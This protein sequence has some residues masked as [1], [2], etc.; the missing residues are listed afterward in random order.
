[1]NFLFAVF[2]L[3]FAPLLQAPN[4][5]AE[6]SVLS[7]SEIQ[8]LAKLVSKYFAA[9]AQESKES[10]ALEKVYSKIQ[11]FEK[12]KKV[13]N[14]LKHCKPWETV[15]DIA[16]DYSKSLSAGSESVQEFQLSEGVK[17][18]YAV[19]M[20]KKYNSKTAWPVLLIIPERGG[21][22]PKDSLSPWKH[23]AIQ[24][25]FILCAPQLP[26]S[27]KSWLEPEGY[28]IVLSCFGRLL[29]Q[30]HV[31][32]NRVL[33][34][35]KGAGAG[36][37][38]SIASYFPSR[39]AGMIA[40]KG[41]LGKVVA[42]NYFNMPSYLSETG[43]SGEE[44]ARRVESLGWNNVT[45]GEESLEK[46]ASWAAGIVRNNY[47]SNITFSPPKNT[48]RSSYWLR[49]DRWESTEGMPADFLPV[50][51]AK[52]DRDKN[53]ITVT[54]N[55]V[56]SYFLFFNDT[57]L[58]LDKPI[59]VMTNGKSWIGTKPR[60]LQNLLDF[61]GSRTGFVFVASQPFDAPPLQEAGSK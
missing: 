48:A 19:S 28:G 47:P 56:Y 3:I 10:E 24:D 40:R 52:A 46:I 15:L 37:A 33:I 43:D 29:S 36:A 7:D 21:E 8:E 59:T 54:A 42:E 35:G 12:K 57:L 41:E 14:L 27:Q 53:Q 2:V 39:F 55:G 23:E 4:K 1:M 30:A 31:D 44:F 25:Q 60:N 11:D 6:K 17:S 58:D 13:D 61:A 16:E 38:A 32:L 5:S 26:E 49:V 50:I 22:S 18:S 45:R 51:Q 20:P 34:V 9:R